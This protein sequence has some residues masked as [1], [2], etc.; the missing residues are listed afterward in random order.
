VSVKREESFQTACTGGAQGHGPPTRR[1]R[2]AWKEMRD[3]V[4]KTLEPPRA[5]RALSLGEVLPRHAT[6]Q[7][8][9][10]ESDISRPRSVTTSP[11]D[12]D[13]TFHETG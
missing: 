10:H 6:P 7:R 4:K 11:Q 9:M 13:V 2:G 8:N 5:K 1:G 3:C 12:T